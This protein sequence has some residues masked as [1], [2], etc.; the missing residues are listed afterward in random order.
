[1]ATKTDDLLIGGGRLFIE[2]YLDDGSLDKKRYFGLTDDLSFN[3]KIDYVEHTNTEEAEERIDF[4]AVK[5]KSA[6]IKFKTSEITAEMLA[7]ALSGNTTDLSVSNDGS[8]TDETHTAVMG[9][10]YE[11][12][13]HY[14]ITDG[15]EAVKYTDD[16]GDEQT[17][18]K[19]TDY[20]IDYK[21]GTLFI[22]KGGA[23]DGKD[24]KVSYDYEKADITKIEALVKKM[25]TAR[26]TFDNKPQNGADIRYTFHK[27]QLTSNGDIKLK[28]TGNFIE[29]SFDGEVLAVD[30][31][32]NP[33]FEV[34]VIN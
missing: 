1:M 16:N 26:L 22:V 20:E 28:D 9:D 33:Y 10:T 12:L 29:V 7:L 14:K 2:R 5:K 4:K 24:I 17:A 6:T 3:S 27:V 23:I 25:V 21:K 8:V 15:S 13:E 31:S 18:V 19:G 34:I 11:D 32:E 30:N